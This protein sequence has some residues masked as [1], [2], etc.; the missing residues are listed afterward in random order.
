VL[1]PVQHIVSLPA[2][3]R[4][5]ADVNATG[6][7]NEG[8]RVSS[9]AAVEH[10]GPGVTR[11]DVVATEAADDVVRRGSDEHVGLR[12]SH[13]RARE[14]SAVLAAAGLSGNGLRLGR[15]SGRHRFDRRFPFHTGRQGERDHDPERRTDQ[16]PRPSGDTRPS[17]HYPLRA[18]AECRLRLDRS[19]AGR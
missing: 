1:D 9:G 10:V 18:R 15:T 5:Q 14:P 2:R 16:E 13:D 7:G 8:D 3:L 12:S 11:E 4:P 6:R 19:Q 17:H